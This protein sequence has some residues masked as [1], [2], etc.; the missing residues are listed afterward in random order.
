MKSLAKEFDTEWN[1]SRKE[2]Y[3]PDDRY[4]LSIISTLEV[5]QWASGI[6]FKKYITSSYK[7]VLK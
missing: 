4:M 5:L 2:G 3:L 1:K 6:K 7:N